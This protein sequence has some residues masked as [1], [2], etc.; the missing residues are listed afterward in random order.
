MSHPSLC[1]VN[2]SDTRNTKFVP[3]L[4]AAIGPSGPLLL[5]DRPVHISALLPE[6]FSIP[7]NVRPINARALLDGPFGNRFSERSAWS[8][9]SCV[10]T[11]CIRG[12]KLTPGLSVVPTQAGGATALQP[13]S[14]IALYTIILMLNACTHSPD[15]ALPRPSHHTSGAY[16]GAGVGA[17][18]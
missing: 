15:G 7:T 12:V 17:T 2:V 14:R 1:F 8:L 16:V 5:P 9:C 13:I 18:R 4:Q 3:F 10:L 6:P 11:A